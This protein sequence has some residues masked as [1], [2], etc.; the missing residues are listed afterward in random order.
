MP[1]E[2]LS[3]NELA[4][5]LGVNPREIREKR[6]LIHR[7]KVMRNEMGLSQAQLA[8]KLKVTQGRIAQIESGI[9][10]RTVSFDLLLH[11]LDT[12]GCDYTITSR[13]AA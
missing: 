1:W 6:K 2:E 11:I 8:K 10:T 7:I 3:L 5:A 4:L 9:G 13:K 12:L